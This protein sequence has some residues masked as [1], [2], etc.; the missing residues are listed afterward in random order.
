MKH[1]P[2]IMPGCFPTLLFLLAVACEP[3]PTPVQSEMIE[4]PSVP[5][6]LRVRTGDE[7]RVGGEGYMVD[8]FI[9]FDCETFDGSK[10]EIQCPVTDARA[11]YAMLRI[12]EGFI[13]DMDYVVELRRD[14]EY[15]ILGETTVVLT[16]EEPVEPVEEVNVRGSVLCDGLPVPGVWI[17][18]GVAWAVTGEDGQYSMRSEKK[19]GLIFMVIPSGYEAPADGSFPEFWHKFS[20][21]D[22]EDEENVDFEL[23]KVDNDVHKM[24]LTADWHIAGRYGDSSW[25]GQTYGSEMLSLE[26][27][28]PVYELALGDLTWDSFWYT[29]SIFPMTWRNLNAHRNHIIFPVIGNHDFDYKCKTQ[30]EA[31]ARY[32]SALGPLCYSMNIGKVHYVVMNDIAYFNS[33]GTVEGRNP[34]EMVSAEDLEW[35]REDLSH[36]DLSTPVV[37]AVHAAVNKFVWS[38]NRW[39]LST[40][41]RNADDLL[42]LFSDFEDVRIVAGHRHISHYMDLKAEGRP[43]AKNRMVE[44]TVPPVGGTL[45]SSHDLCGFDIGTDGCPPCYEVCEVNGKDFTFTFRSYGEDENF[46]MRCYDMNSVKKF[47]DTDSRVNTLYTAKAMYSYSSLFGPYEANSVFINVFAGDPR[48]ENIRVEVFEGQTALPV[49]VVGVY[50]PQHV[51][52]YDV[53]AYTENGSVNSA[54]K[55]VVS[56]HIFKVV[57]SDAET[58]LTVKLTD[59]YGRVYTQQVERPK[60][61][62]SYTKY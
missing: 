32:R 10:L 44:Y 48:M 29:N 46:Q 23:V 28:V 40:I 56:S 55:S 20:S 37:L 52:S 1:M 3:V 6:I 24:I 22:A 25:L 21:V 12:A 30:L 57:A 41:V 35:L 13:S 31:S 2:D 4:N 43:Y 18:D 54:F 33:T 26:S 8:D 34:L 16:D 27:E 62:S 17:S 5:S 53:L 38:G 14:G 11:D 61:F 47:W 19:Y 58:D 51:A 7:V 45:W 15:Q 36:V 42:G 39:M 49:T 50:D 59:R 9:T 60:A